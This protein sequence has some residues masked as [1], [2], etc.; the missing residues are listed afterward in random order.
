MYKVVR[1]FVAPWDGYLRYAGETISGDVSAEILRDLEGSGL[2]EQEKAPEKAA[3]KAEQK[4][5]A[6]KKRKG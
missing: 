2:I 3:P 1:T 5:A 6:A 4:P